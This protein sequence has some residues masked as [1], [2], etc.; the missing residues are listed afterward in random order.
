MED[1]LLDMTSIS[2]VHDPSPLLVELAVCLDH[3]SRPSL[4]LVCLPSILYCSV[5]FFVPGAMM[6]KN[7]LFICH[8]S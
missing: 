4:A 7:I 3:G 5:S 1:D 2:L 6:M 8:C